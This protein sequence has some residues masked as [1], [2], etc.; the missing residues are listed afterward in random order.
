MIFIV[1]YILLKILIVIQEMDRNDA[2]ADEVR[3]QQRIKNND[4]KP[5]ISRNAPKAPRNSKKTSNSET[6][7]ESMDITTSSSTT[8]EVGKFFL[9]SS[10]E[11]SM[12]V[13]FYFLC[14]YY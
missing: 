7:T 2:Q 5:K 3:K 10:S 11:T 12:F 9:S 8:T 6:I 1:S 4:V 13:W 14:R